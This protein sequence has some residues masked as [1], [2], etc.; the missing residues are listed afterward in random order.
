MTRMRGR[1]NPVEP[2]LGYATGRTTEYVAVLLEMSPAD[3]WAGRL[4]RFVAR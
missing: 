3:S 1:K 4:R 2:D